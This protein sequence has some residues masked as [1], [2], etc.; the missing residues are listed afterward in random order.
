M[1]I[2]NPEN[3]CKSLNENF[4]K[5]NTAVVFR[6]LLFTGVA[7]ESMELEIDVLSD[8]FIGVSVEGKRKLINEEQ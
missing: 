3:L 7:V 1:Y 5:M 8:A 6:S 2:V 4:S